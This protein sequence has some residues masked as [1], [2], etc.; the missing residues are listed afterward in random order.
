MFNI[1]NKRNPK[2]VKSD[3]SGCYIYSEVKS[4]SLSVNF[5]L[6]GLDDYNSM[7]L[8]W[9]TYNLCGIKDGEKLFYRTKRF[10]RKNHY[11]VR[12]F[13]RGLSSLYSHFCVTFYSTKALLFHITL[14]KAIIACKNCFINTVM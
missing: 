14:C 3:H 6:L 5:S 13:R 11:Q 1:L 12:Y 8:V 4:H 7:E 10:V 9:Y 2:M